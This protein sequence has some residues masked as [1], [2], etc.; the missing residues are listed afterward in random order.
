MMAW[1]L[2]LL[3]STAL[4]GADG[5]EISRSRG[6]KGGVVVLYPRV[7][8]ESQDPAIVAVA[9]QLQQRLAASAAR[10]VGDRTIDVRPAPER[11]CPQSGCKAASV[12][13]LL[14]H[15]QGGCVAVAMVGGPGA[16][17]QQLLPL[18]GKVQLHAAVATF[19]QPPERLVTVTEFVPCGEV[20]GALDLTAVEAA[21]AAA[22]TETAP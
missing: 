8:P 7:V 14:G 13:V 11:V 18:V 12:G 1:W 19:R 4:A 15:S 5:D 3:A 6:K 10:A 9:A 21:V 17:N 20:L 22:S 16:S 2:A